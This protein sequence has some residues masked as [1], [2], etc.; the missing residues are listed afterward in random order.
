MGGIAGL[1]ENQETPTKWKWS[2]PISRVL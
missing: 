1:G 2:W